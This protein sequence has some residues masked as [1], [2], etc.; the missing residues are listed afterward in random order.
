MYKGL[1]NGLQ[2][3]L[4]G[5]T[6]TR[7]FAKFISSNISC[8]SQL[9][10]VM[11]PGAREEIFE[12]HIKISPAAGNWLRCERFIPYPI[13]S[14]PFLIARVWSESWAR[15]YK[16]RKRRLWKTVAPGLAELF[17]YSF[18]PRNEGK[19]SSWI[20]EKDILP[21]ADVNYCI[22]ILQ[23]SWRGLEASR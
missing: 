18:R 16:S 20:G 15:Q 1:L 4:R 11:Y 3:I 23:G 12:L 10:S 7:T 17:S 5:Q 2:R 19:Q 14:C 13:K 8:Q 9:T 22:L 6:P 21:L